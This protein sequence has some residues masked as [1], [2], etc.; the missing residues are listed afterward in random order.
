MKLIDCYRYAAML[1]ASACCTASP[2]YG[3]LETGL[4]EAQLLSSLKACKSWKVR[5][6]TPT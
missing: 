3:P 5:E 4:Q 6:R 2:L 1:Y